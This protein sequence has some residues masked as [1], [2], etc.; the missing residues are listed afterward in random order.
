MSGKKQNIH[1]TENYTEAKFNV[2]F[3]SV[4]VHQL[5]FTASIFLRWQEKKSSG[6][7]FHTSKA[8]SEVS[9]TSMLFWEHQQNSL[10]NFANCLL[11]CLFPF[12]SS[13]FLT[14]THPIALSSLL[15]VEE[16]T[17][18]TPVDFIQI[19]NESWIFSS[20]SKLNAWSIFVW[21]LQFW[22]STRSCVVVRSPIFFV[23]SLKFSQLQFWKHFFQFD[24]LLQLISKLLRNISWNLTGN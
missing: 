2:K 4:C 19:W 10:F 13:G 21:Q 14:A 7:F 15:T 12:L 11:F 9:L 8:Q 24:F 20:L 16:W 17:E 1:L 22:W 18:K 3:L 5:T 23:S 6:I